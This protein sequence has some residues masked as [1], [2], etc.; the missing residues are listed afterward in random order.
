MHEHFNTHKCSHYRA[1][2]TGY[3]K[4]QMHKHARTNECMC[5]TQSRAPGPDFEPMSEEEARNKKLMRSM[6]EAGLSGQM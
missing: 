3:A 2:M 5:I 4:A 6:K 1:Q